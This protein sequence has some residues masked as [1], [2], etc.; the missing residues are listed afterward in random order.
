MLKETQQRWKSISS[1]NRTRIKVATAIV[2]LSVFVGLGFDD[3]IARVAECQANVK[4]YVT[5]EFSEDY[6]VPYTY[7][8]GQN[9]TCSGVR[10]E[11]RYWSKPASSINSAFTRDGKLESNVGGEPRMSRGFY[12]PPIP[13]VNVDYSRDY[14]FDG[15][16]DHTD[17]GLYT[18][19]TDGTNAGM[20]ASEYLSCLTKI[21][22]R[23]QVN[24]WYGWQYGA[25]L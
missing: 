18:I 13:R 4:T 3:H 7:S 2:A 16:R 15:Y 20:N 10:T 9:M 19:F 22:D 1:T 23:V 5:A 17:K 8:C 11:T 14:D 25:E 21:G 6:L 12:T 24:T